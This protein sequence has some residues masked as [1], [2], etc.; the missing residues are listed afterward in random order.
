MGNSS[1]KSKSSKIDLEQLNKRIVD[2]EQFD[3]DNDGILKKEEL[4]F[5]MKKQKDDIKL[6]TRSIKEQ[7]EMKYQKDI[8][9]AEKKLMEIRDENS[10]LKKQLNAL[11]NINQGLENKIVNKEIKITHSREGTTKKIELS[12]LSKHRIEQFVNKLLA[13]KDINIQYLPDFV[14]KQLYKNV[15]TILLGLL[16]NI[17]DTTSIKFLGHDLTFELNPSKAAENSDSKDDNKD[18]KN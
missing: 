12:E 17:L 6:L 4:E 18:E 5:A 1:S 9:N 2:L 8:L 16:E 7:I 11:K 13:D 3:R 14:E 10:E 15:F